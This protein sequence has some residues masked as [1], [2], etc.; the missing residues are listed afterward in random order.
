M[1]SKEI[2][3]SLAIIQD[4]N[5]DL[6]YSETKK[7]IEESKTSDKYYEYIDKLSILLDHKKSYIRTRAFMIICA[8]SRWD[9]DNKIKSLLP[10]LLKFYHDEKPTV[11]RQSLNASKEILLYLPALSKSIKQELDSIDL[12]AY[13]DSM[14]PLIEKDIEEL[15][16]S[17]N[18]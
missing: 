7:I 12:S 13:K 1:F 10:Q 5:D 11:V 8:Q 3:E 17:L 6:A 14:A 15:K 16:K 4:S 9:K 2:E 18:H